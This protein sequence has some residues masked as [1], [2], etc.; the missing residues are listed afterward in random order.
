MILVTAANGRTGRSMIAALAHQG[1]PVRA[2][3]RDAAQWPQLEA[4]GATD[5]ALGDL[6]D[7]ASI[8]RA[9]TGAQRVV[10]IGPPMHPEEVTFVG[11]FQHGVG[12]QRLLDFSL[13][14]Q[15][16]QLQQAYRLLQ[17]RRHCELLPQL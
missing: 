12:F 14:I 6:G 9:L 13:K 3:I 11:H 5:Y 2:F 7:P 8:D 4:L 1:V 17:L 15:R 16:R 10:F